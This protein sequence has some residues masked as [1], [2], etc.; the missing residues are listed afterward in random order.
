MIK[1]YDVVR[2]LGQASILDRGRQCEFSLNVT[3]VTVTYH[4][5]SHFL[6]RKL[7]LRLHEEDR[8]IFQS[9]RRRILR[10]ICPNLICME[11]KKKNWRNNRRRTYIAHIQNIITIYKAANASQSTGA[12]HL[13]IPSTASEGAVLT[14]YNP[15]PQTTRTTPTAFLTPSM[16]T[17]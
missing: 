9:F 11:C 3:Q 17:S 15:V 1:I 10:K 16:N 13:S 6:I 14:T 5:L 2:T 12:Y 7:N 4:R 8:R